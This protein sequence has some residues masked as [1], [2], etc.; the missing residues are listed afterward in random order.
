MYIAADAFAGEWIDKVREVEPDAPLL[1]TA[2]GVYYYFP[3]EKVIGLH[4]MLKGHGHIESVFDTVN[5]KGMKRMGHYMEKVGHSDAEMF[6]YVD[7]PEV[8][9]GEAGCRLLK[10]EPYYSHTDRNGMKFMTSVSM[11][12]SDRYM[13]VKM[14]HLQVI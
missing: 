12:V 3:K 1:V 2:S 6:F 9:A 4:Q 5:S 11:K 13:M 8:M 14:I 10:E 7:D